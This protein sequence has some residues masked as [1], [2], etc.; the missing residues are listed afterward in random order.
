MNEYSRKIAQ[1]KKAQPYLSTADLVYETLLNLIISHKLPPGSKVTQEELADLMEVS[2]S[3]VR[4]AIFRLEQEKFIEKVPRLGYCVN[5]L[6]ARDYA[7][8]IDL[9][10][11]LESLAARLAAEQ[12]TAEEQ[13]EMIES[14]EKIGEAQAAGDREKMLEL[15][16][17][18]HE[19][20][21]RHSKNQYLIDV[22]ASLRPRIEF[23]LHFVVQKPYYLSI[24]Q[25]HKGICNAIVD[26]KE[27]LASERLIK[28]LS[29]S[30]SKSLD[31]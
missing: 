29:V 23:F 10:C 13:Q 9:R 1:L 26:R 21:I 20:I 30:L 17:E 4:E 31:N 12:Q 3:P 18:F 8:M 5:Q 11:A 2:R 28:H 7:Q 22:Y 14:T 6:S 19:M 27:D 15:D 24:Y 16:L 25:R